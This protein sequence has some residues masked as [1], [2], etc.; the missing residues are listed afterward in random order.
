M[1]KTITLFVIV[2]L[3][4]NCKTANTHLYTVIIYKLYTYVHAYL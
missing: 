3:V 2:I 1:I 4:N